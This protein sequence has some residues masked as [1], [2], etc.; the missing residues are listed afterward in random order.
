V[1]AAEFRNAKAKIAE[2]DEICLQQQQEV[3]LDWQF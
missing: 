2:L 3:R 1:E